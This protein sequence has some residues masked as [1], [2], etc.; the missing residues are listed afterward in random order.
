MQTNVTA[1]TYTM[2]VNHLSTDV[3]QLIEYINKN[4]SISAL[5]IRID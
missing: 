2:A 1:N 5:A 4:K 3:S